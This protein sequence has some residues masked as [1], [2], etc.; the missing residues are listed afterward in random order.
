MQ[1]KNAS[2]SDNQQERLKTIGWIIGFVDGEGCF[3][4]SI[5]KNRRAGKLGWQV[6]PE[7]V[8]SQEKK[9]LESLQGIQKF[10]GCGRIYVNRLTRKNE[11]HNEELYRYCIRSVKDLNERIIPFFRA[12][13][14]RTAKQ[15]DFLKFVQIVELITQKKHLSLQGLRRVAKIIEKMNRKT[16]SKFLESSETIRQTGA[17]N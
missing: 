3:S 17:H 13:S 8:V 6:F 2:N 10:F 12:N 16:P 15:N 7:F 14:L 11:N 4:V 1:S 5:F 9:S